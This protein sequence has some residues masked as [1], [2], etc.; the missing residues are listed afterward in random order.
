[1]GFLE[2]YS[3]NGR[4]RSILSIR[5]GLQS[6]FQ[7]FSPRFSNSA[8]AVVCRPTQHSQSQVG[9]AAGAALF[10][11]GLVPL[12]AGERPSPAGFICPFRHRKTID[13]TETDTP[14][15]DAI[16]EVGP[17]DASLEIVSLSDVHGYLDSARSALRAVGEIG[18]RAPV[19]EPDGEGNLHWADNE[20]VLVFNGDLVDRGPDSAETVDLAFRLMREAPSGRV[21]YHLGN[22]EMAILLPQVLNW[23]DTYSHELD[24]D[25]RRE[26]IETVASGQVTAAFEG[27]NH[28]Y[29]HAGDA[30]TLDV[31]RLNQQTRT[32]ARTLLAAI[33]EGQFDSTQKA[34]PSEYSD[35]FGLGDPFGR[36]PEAGVLWMDFSHMPA[37]APSQIVGHTMHSEPTRKGQTLCQ[38]VI[39]QNQGSDGGEGVFVE[40]AE[41]VIAATRTEDGDV[42]T[43]EI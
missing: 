19:V 24:S 40:S 32:A 43:T 18:G 22:H 12:T 7:C 1:M 13:S 25:T 3:T 37:D 39:R 31:S 4:G 27:Y 33:S 23:V 10:R 42:H 21:R 14:S 34:I 2:G 20:Y 38:N 16:S 6:R 26:F 9:T 30:T 15:H 41:S 5:L 17:A 36:G 28:V 11:S 8:Y 29:T 35:V